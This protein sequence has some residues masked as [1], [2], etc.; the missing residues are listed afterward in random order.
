M[1][2]TPLARFLYTAALA[3][4][5]L[6][7][8]VAAGKPAAAGHGHCGFIE[9]AP[10]HA[11]DYSVAPGVRPARSAGPREDKNAL[12]DMGFAIGPTLTF[13]KAVVTSTTNARCIAARRADD[14]PGAGGRLTAD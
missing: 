3:V 13:P 2:R 12:F 10:A 4:S 6:A 1:F 7:A 9:T 11:G 5:L 14:A 8:A